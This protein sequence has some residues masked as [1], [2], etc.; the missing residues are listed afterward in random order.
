EQ[1]HVLDRD[2]GL[3]REG[4]DELDLRS[5]KWLH[6]MSTTSNG[7]DR[8]AIQQEGNS[9]KRSVHGRALQ[10]FPC[11]GVIVWI[12]LDIL[13]MYS[14]AIDEGP[15][16]GKVSSRRSWKNRVIRSRLRRRHVIHRYEMKQSSP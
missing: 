2:H 5:R 15:T 13:D 14:P 1:S 7:A 8:H 10:D 6:L 12:P 16:D 9:Q 11:P 4:L 3:V